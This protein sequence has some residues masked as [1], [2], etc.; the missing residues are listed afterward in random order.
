MKKMECRK[1]MSGQGL[2]IFVNLLLSMPV[3]FFLELSSGEG[4]P[5]A[6]LARQIC[7]PQGLRDLNA[8]FLTEVTID[9]I[10][11]CG[12]G[13]GV[14]ILVTTWIFLRAE[15]TQ[16]P[17]P[18]ALWREERA[19]IVIGAVLCALPLSYLPVL[20]AWWQYYRQRTET[21][22]LYDVLWFVSLIVCSVCIYG[23]Y[24]FAVKTS[25]G[26]TAR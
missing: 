4:T 16:R 15:A 8:V 18:L 1:R 17:H 12:L 10:L 22:V 9:S 23:L 7:N 20:A 5:G 6:F 19:C 21:G 3:S 14:Y 13:W 26:Q 25:V 24:A 11:L 2:Q